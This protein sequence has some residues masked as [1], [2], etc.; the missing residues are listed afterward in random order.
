MLQVGQEQKHAPL[1]TRGSETVLSAE[2]MP[3]R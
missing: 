1:G 3:E 2:I